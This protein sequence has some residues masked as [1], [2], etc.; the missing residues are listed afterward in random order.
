VIKKGIILLG[1][2]AGLSSILSYLLNHY[3]SC[4][5]QEWWI[6]VIVYAG[7]FLIMHLLYL[8]KTEGKTYTGLLFGAIT[9]KLIILLIFIFLYSIFRSNTLNIFA[10]HFFG[11]YIL[12]TVPE[13]RYLISLIK[14]TNSKLH[15]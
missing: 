13:I 15:E 12:F 2:S 6:S 1:V 7:I 8:I 14:N 11:H 4:Y 10:I 9:L 5:N 3:F